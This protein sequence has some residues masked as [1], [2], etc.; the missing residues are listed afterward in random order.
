MA[1]SIPL[2]PLHI[3]TLISLLLLLALVLPLGSSKKVD[4]RTVLTYHKGPLLT[5]D[6]NLT[7]LWYGRFGRVQKSTIRNFIR[8]L[9]HNGNFNLEPRVSTWWKTIESYQSIKS[10][11]HHKNPS[12]RVQVVKQMTDNSYSVGKILTQNSIPGLVQKAKSG[13]VAVIFT[14]RDVSVQGLCTGKC[15]Q[16]GIMGKG[17]LHQLYIMVGNPESECPGE[18]GWP[19]HKA[20]QGPQSLPLQPPNGD[21]GADAMVIGFA[22]ALAG[23]VTNPYKNGYFQGPKTNPLE[24]VSACPGMFGSGAFPGYAGKVH[25]DPHDGGCFNAHGVNGKKFLLPAV[26]NPKTSACWTTM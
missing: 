19:F 12:I 5:G 1:S 7:I 10:S 13:S 26:W 17:S 15:S 22:T 21:I 6:L 8:S 3:S 18:C 16:H 25:V 20:D 14:A 9:N 23:T 4:I 2:N 24:A 11:R